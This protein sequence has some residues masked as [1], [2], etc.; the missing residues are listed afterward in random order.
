MMRGM[1]HL[2]AED[3]E[4]IEE[5]V[6]E[7]ADALGLRDWLITVS[8]DSLDENAVIAEIRCVNGRKRARISFASYFK[9]LDLDVQR[10]VVVHELLHVHWE[11][12][13][14]VLRHDIA[15]YLGQ[16]LYDHT[17]QS[18]RRQAE[19]GIDG[20]AHS[21]AHYLPLPKWEVNDEEEPI[22]ETIDFKEHPTGSARA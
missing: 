20:I 21:I 12:A 7:L 11:G 1:A 5:Y 3:C 14:S 16:L 6:R 13:W 10:E 9:S 2:S 8:S 4:A 17:M 22:V 18:F 15:D 19:I